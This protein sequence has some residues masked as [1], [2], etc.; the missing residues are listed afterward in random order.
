M[1]YMNKFSYIIPTYNVKPYVAECLDSILAQTYPNWE[2]ICVDDGSPDGLGKILDQ[3]AAK[4][5]RFRI[6][7]QKNKGVGAARNA[8]LEVMTGDWFLFVDGDDVSSPYT[9]EI[10]ERALNSYPDVDMLMFHERRFPQDGHCDWGEKPIELRMEYRDVHGVVNSWTYSTGHCTRAYRKSVFGHFRN[11]ELVRGQDRYFL[12]DCVF[13]VNSIVKIDFAISGVRCRIGS[14][15]RSPINKRKL[16]ATIKFTRH[17]IML[18]KNSNRNVA[19]PLIRAQ[20]NKFVEG[21][22]DE[23]TQ[24]TNPLD[25]K[26]M[27]DQW[28]SCVR[29]F[30]REHF[31]GRFQSLRMKIIG[32]VPLIGLIWLFCRLPYN[33]KRLGI[34]R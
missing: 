20:I 6:I 15:T 31:I 24:L 19:S 18:V 34:H 21:Y 8:G 33:L 32:A 13:N 5:S 27:L 25:K 3:Y 9:C 1:S 30:S 16:D 7:H 29:E 17:M 22:I 11:P 2:C 26:E 28:L 14:Q 4:D 12:L 10:C 23:W